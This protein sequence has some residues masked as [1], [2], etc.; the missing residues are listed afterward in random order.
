[1][2]T[3]VESSVIARRMETALVVDDCPMIRML[4]TKFLS[5]LGLEV[6]SAK[7]GVEAVAVAGEGHF[8]LIVMDLEMPRMNGIEATTELRAMGVDCKIIG[9]TGCND[10]S[11]Q[12]RFMDAGLDSLFNKPLTVAN[13]QSCLN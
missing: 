2:A 13:L 6:S 9:A 8:D 7:D 4:N 5:K 11:L 1:M 12:Q 3:E 10:V